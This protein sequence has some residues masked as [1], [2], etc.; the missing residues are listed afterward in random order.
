M[1]GHKLLQHFQS[2]HQRLVRHGAVHPRHGDGYRRHAGLMYLDIKV[3]GIDQAVSDLLTKMDLWNHVIACNNETGGVILDRFE[4]WIASVQEA[5]DRAVAGGPLA[6]AVPTR[7][8]AYAVSAMFL[9]IELMT[10]L[11]PSRSA[12]RPE[13]RSH[14]SLPAAPSG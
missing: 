4:E 9:G 14:D 8:A 13:R 6:G 11:D 1:L 7:Q 2:A 3:Q 5:L 12:R 10:R